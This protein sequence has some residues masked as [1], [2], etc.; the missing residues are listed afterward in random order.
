MKTDKQEHEQLCGNPELPHT[1]NESEKRKLV[2]CSDSL[3][4]S[5]AD[6]EQNQTD[7][8]EEHPENDDI[9]ELPTLFSLIV[10]R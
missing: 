4:A 7:L 3:K 5:S 2:S 6:V 10:Q 9:Y 8:Q 1:A